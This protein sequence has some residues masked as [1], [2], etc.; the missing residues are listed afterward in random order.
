M[1]HSNLIYCLITL[2]AVAITCKTQDQ[3]EIVLTRVFLSNP[4][5]LMEIKQQILA[6]D[7]SVL[8]AYKKLCSEADSSMHAGPFSVMDKPFIPPSGDKHDYMSVGPYWWPNPDTDDGLPYIRKDGIGNPANQQYDSKPRNSMISHVTTLALAYWYSDHEPYAMHA[9][10]LLRV[11]F[12]DEETRMT[13]HAQYAQAIPGINE[14]RGIG[15]I[16]M[17]GLSDIADAIGLIGS[18][19]HWTAKDQ[20]GM[21][22]WF[23]D[24]LEWLIHS[25]FGKEVAPRKNNIAS[26]YD[27]IA[28]HL[29]LFVGNDT[30]AKAIFDSFSVRRIAVMIEPDGSQP[31]ELHRTR[32]F[33]YSTWNLEAFFRIALLAEHL[34]MDLWNETTHDGRGLKVAFDFLIPYV[35]GEKE[36]PYQMIRGWGDGMERMIFLMKLASQKYQQPQ[37]A[38]WISDLPDIDVKRHRVNL[39]Y[40]SEAGEES[41]KLDSD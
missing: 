24:F 27:V 5:D 9:V 15:I 14:G 40:R 36:W 20:Q 23:S 22:R 11:W 38:R 35:R 28:G 41:L 1:K 37:Y 30:V 29:A 31:H 21:Q 26:W 33:A 13:P 39:R 19:Q 6:G 16:D 17:H 3:T 4:H 7:A 18:S 32:S 10:K 34:D 25:N 12:L 2:F 8:P